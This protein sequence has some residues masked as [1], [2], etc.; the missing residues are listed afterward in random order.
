[1][2]DN[3]CLLLSDAFMIEHP[4]KISSKNSIGKRAK[5]P[6]AYGLVRNSNAHQKG[7]VFIK[8]CRKGYYQEG[9][10]IYDEL[11]IFEAFRKVMTTWA[12]WID[13]NVDTKKTLVLF[14]GYSTSHFR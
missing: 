8:T 2:D 12:R 9:S 1:M 14:R 11:N 6:N 5:T 7:T 10:H 13:A 4:H 3:R